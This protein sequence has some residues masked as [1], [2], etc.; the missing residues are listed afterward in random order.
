[1]VNLEDVRLAF[2]NLTAFPTD[3]QHWT[4][5]RAL[6]ISGNKIGTIPLFAAGLTTLK[7][8]VVTANP[9][10]IIPLQLG[11][12]VD[13]RRFEYD[14]HDR[15]VSPPASVMQQG[16]DVALVY[17]KAFY[18]ARISCSFNASEL[19]MT[20]VPVE[21]STL[22]MLKELNLQVAALSRALSQCFLIHF[23]AAQ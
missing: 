5:L 3:A 1:M 12:L 22:S 9:L 2:N 11:A 15:W 17:L 18:N 7:K 23:A 19:G 20:Q 21:L 16:A 6:D 13:L 8:L 14:E 4:Q 10:V